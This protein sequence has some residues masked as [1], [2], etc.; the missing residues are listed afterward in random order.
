MNIP[1][2]DFSTIDT[3]GNKVKREIVAGGELLHSDR[4]LGYREGDPMIRKMYREALEKEGAQLDMPEEL[5]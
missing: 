1:M 4:A 3:R 2:L 5:Y